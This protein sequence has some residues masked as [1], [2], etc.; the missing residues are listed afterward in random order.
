MYVRECTVRLRYYRPRH[1]YISTTCLYS[2]AF[3]RLRISSMHLSYNTLY[4]FNCIPLCSQTTS[5]ATHIKN[6]KSTARANAP[7]MCS[8]PNSGKHHSYPLA[9]PNDSRPDRHHRRENRSGA[10]DI[11]LRY[12]LSCAM[13]PF[14]EHN[15]QKQPT[16]QWL[17]SNYFYLWWCTNT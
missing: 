12:L 11:P 6:L 4:L 14:C 3:G 8:P 7:R 10:T 16:S 1:R 15:R 9:R 13:S 5:T 17:W 2:P